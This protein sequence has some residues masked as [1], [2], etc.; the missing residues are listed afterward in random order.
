MIEEKR[1]S[2]TGPTAPDAPHSSRKKTVR[3]RRRVRILL[4]QVAIWLDNWGLRGY[5]HDTHDWASKTERLRS[6][7]NTTRHAR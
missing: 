1:S 7:K 2:A 5:P 6:L 4:L 3:T